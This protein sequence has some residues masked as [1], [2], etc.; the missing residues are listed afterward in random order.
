[1]QNN[2]NPGPAL[3]VQPQFQGPFLIEL[4]YLSSFG[5]PGFAHLFSPPWGV[6]G[7]VSPSFPPAS[8]LSPRL[9]LKA[10]PDQE[11]PPTTDQI[12]PIFSNPGEPLL[13][14]S[15]SLSQS[16]ASQQSAQVDQTHRR[17]VNLSAS[18]FSSVNWGCPPPCL[19]GNNRK[20]EW[21]QSPPP[22]PSSPTSTQEV[23]ELL[24]ERQQKPREMLKWEIIQ[25]HQPARGL[26]I[27]GSARGRVYPI[28]VVRLCITGALQHCVMRISLG[29][30][31]AYD[32]RPHLKFGENESHRNWGLHP[33]I[34]IDLDTWGL[35]MRGGIEVGRE[36]AQS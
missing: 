23:P 32:N 5:H 6:W 34:R 10:S 27:G 31:R 7:G 20:Q 25:V 12:P 22:C 15:A 9:S 29:S 14:P 2:P 26:S 1:M 33:E 17:P 11:C 35:G 21:G 24:P 36:R 4:H 8:S 30:G 16:Q 13:W 18:V 3:F 19:V 28:G